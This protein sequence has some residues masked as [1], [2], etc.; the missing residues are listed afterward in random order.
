MRMRV[1]GRTGLEVSAVSLGAWEIGGAVTFTFDEL[2]TI[3]HGWGARD[4]SESIDLITRCRDAGVN[5][6]DTAPMYGGGHSEEVIGRALADCRDHWVVCTKGGEGATDGIAWKDFSRERLLWQI[7]ESLRRLR[8]DHVDVYLLHGPSAED[9]ARGECFEAIEEIRGQGKARFVGVS[10]G[11]NEMG[12]ELIERGVVDVVQ[13]AISIINPSAAIGLLPAAVEHN[14]GIVA[15]GVFSAGFLTGAVTAD[16]QFAADDRRSWQS[17]DS[18]RAT[19]R[20][21][22]ALR[23]LTGPG[24]SPAQLAIQYVLGLPGVSTIITGT[25]SWAHMEENIAAAECPALTEDELTHI[26]HVMDR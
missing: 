7:D 4:D 15:R 25:G 26:A 13:Q 16:T 2:G 18:K 20:K 8:M 14:V 12:V 17:D 24:R 3:P 9:I 21:A 11:P 1:L 6:I 5:L 10:I 22:D 23:P 19:V